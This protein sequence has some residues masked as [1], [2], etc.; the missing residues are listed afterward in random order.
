MEKEVTDFGHLLFRFYS[1][2]LSFQLDIQN[3]LYESV[4]ET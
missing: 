3:K 2:V 4:I 1:V